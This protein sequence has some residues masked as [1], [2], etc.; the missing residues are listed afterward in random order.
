MFLTQSFADASAKK[1]NKMTT[2]SGHHNASIQPQK[3][4][5]S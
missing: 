4:G 3:D 5:Y 2:L 1:D